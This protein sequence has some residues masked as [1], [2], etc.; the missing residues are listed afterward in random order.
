MTFKDQAGAIL[1]TLRKA[2]HAE[3]MSKFMHTQNCSRNWKHGS[4]LTPKRCTHRSHVETE[5]ITTSTKSIH[6]HKSCRSRKQQLEL[7][8]TSST[9]TTHA[10]NRSHTHKSAETK[11]NQLRWRVEPRLKKPCP[12][13]K[14]V[15]PTPTKLVQTFRIKS[16]TTNSCCHHGNKSVGY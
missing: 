12:L 14:T 13:Q 1:V 9:I 6:T 3:S 2:R 16:L 4:Q 7:R 5:S 8:G 11:F 15:P 10:E